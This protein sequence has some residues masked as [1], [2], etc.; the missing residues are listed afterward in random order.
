LYMRR[1]E[2]VIGEGW[3]E[4]VEGQKLQQECEAFG[5]K[6]DASMRFRRWQDEVLQQNR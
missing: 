5:S 2:S 6:L 1:M 4:H 3:E